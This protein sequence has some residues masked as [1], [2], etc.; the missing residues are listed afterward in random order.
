MVLGRGFRLLRT[1]PQ[2]SSHVCDITPSWLRKF[3]GNLD[4]E[5]VDQ[6]IIL[7]VQEGGKAWTTASWRLVTAMKHTGQECG[8]RPSWSS[9]GFSRSCL[10]KPRGEDS[11][12]ELA[13]ACAG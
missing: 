6:P 13:G 8:L 10:S 7:H 12:S 2:M 3:C 1:Q 5:G 9:A 4:A 11:Y